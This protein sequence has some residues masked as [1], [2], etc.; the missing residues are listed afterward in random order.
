[1]L[2]TGVYFAGVEGRNAGLPRA[3]VSEIRDFS[4]ASYL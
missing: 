3:F 4:L 2:S 1:M